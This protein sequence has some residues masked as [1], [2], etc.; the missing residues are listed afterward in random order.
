MK[1]RP[2]HTLQRTGLERF[3]CN[4]CVPCAGSLS[5][6]RRLHTLTMRDIQTVLKAHNQLHGWSCAASAH[7]FIAK[8]HEKIGLADYPL[9]NDPTSQRGGFQFEAFLSSIGFAGH[10]DHLLPPDATKLVCHRDC[11][12]A[13]SAGVH[14]GRHRHRLY[15]LAHR[16]H[17]SI[18]H[19]G[20]FGRP[21]EAVSHYSD[22]RRDARTSSGCCGCRAGPR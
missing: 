15:L 18:R 2:H 8:I 11:Q 6:V 19:R 13:I 9:Q 1:Q 7:E 21:C 20:G 22:H 14:S 4:R 12:A 16:S 5:S 3:S 10:D 17:S